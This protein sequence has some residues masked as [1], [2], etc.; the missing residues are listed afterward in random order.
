M[1]ASF[2][3][4]AGLEAVL[5]RSHSAQALLD[6]HLVGVAAYGCDQRQAESDDRG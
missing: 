4:V 3:A 2:L 5:A 6:D 1:S